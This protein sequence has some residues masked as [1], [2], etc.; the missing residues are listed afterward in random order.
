MGETEPGTHGAFSLSADPWG[1]WGKL[2]T[3]NQKEEKKE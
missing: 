2:G 3:R 1:T